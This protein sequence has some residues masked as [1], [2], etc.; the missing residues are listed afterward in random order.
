MLVV[1]KFAILS[2]VPACQPVFPLFETCCLISAFAD[3]HNIP[4]FLSP[5][6]RAEIASR[7]R[8]AVV[9][10][11]T[12]DFRLVLLVPAAA[13]PQHSPGLPRR[14]SLAQPGPVAGLQGSR[15]SRTRTFLWLC[16]RRRRCWQPLTSRSR[17]ELPTGT[18]QAPNP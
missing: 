14:R 7:G 6:A 1:S 18:G 13:A 10:S 15:L 2:L 12:A 8:S 9:V 16:R 4:Q 5:K 11:R 17:P 3:F